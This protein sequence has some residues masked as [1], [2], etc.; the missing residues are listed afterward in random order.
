MISRYPS[1]S[2]WVRRR[3][4]PPATSRPSCSFRGRS[5]SLSLSLD[6]STSLSRSSSLDL[7]TSLSPSLSPS[8]RLLAAQKI[9]EGPRPPTRTAHG[10]GWSSLQAF[11]RW[12]Y[13]SKTTCLIRPDSLYACFV[14]SRINISCYVARHF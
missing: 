8:L 14:V 6:L 5:L 13:F 12:H 1:R 11:I 9:T 4:P 3:L 2:C 7:S 10:Q